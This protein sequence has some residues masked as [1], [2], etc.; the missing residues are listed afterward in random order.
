MDAISYTAARNN[1]SN[2]MEKVCNDHSPIIITRK[3]SEPVVMMSLDDYN[4]LM[5]TVY[6]LRSSKN[7]AN[8]AKSIQDLK[9]GNVVKKED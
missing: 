5:E 6:L 7:A 4:S 8:L 1:F 2:T 9:D 3:N